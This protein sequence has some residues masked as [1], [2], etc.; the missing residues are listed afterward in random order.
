MKF[1]KWGST[2]PRQDEIIASQRE[3]LNEET[4]LVQQKM[5]DADQDQQVAQR[6]L[7]EAQ[8]VSHEAKKVGAAL[9]REEELN[10]LALIFYRGLAGGR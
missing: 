1:W 6:K 5:F 8:E 7:V 2:S 3:K 9:E 4:A 10:G